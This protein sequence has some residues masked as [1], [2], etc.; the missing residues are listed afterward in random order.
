MLPLPSYSVFKL[1]SLLAKY[2]LK[3]TLIYYSLKIQ[4]DG[5]PLLYLRDDLVS[6]FQ[7]PYL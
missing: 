5:G 7:A 6:L 2:A 4:I 1:S 3:V